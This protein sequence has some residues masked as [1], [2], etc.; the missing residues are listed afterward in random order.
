[1]MSSEIPSKLFSGKGSRFKKGLIEQPSDGFVAEVFWGFLNLKI[2][3]RRSVVNSRYH[4][5][6]IRLI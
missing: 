2:N 6:I 4:I 5:Q 1:M 3:I